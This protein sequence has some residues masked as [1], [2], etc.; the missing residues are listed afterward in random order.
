MPKVSA[1]AG[2]M[3]HYP[4]VDFED[5]IENHNTPKVRSVPPPGEDMDEEDAGLAIHRW[6]QLK[7]VVCVESGSESKG[8]AISRLTGEEDVH[9]I[10]DAA[11]VEKEISLV[12][13]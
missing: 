4:N 1:V 6:K 12:L 7:M 10:T 13:K 5:F 8:T 2:F 3:T 11:E 9:S